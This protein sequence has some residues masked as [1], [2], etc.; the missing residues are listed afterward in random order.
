MK[1]SMVRQVR[2]KIGEIVW[3][4]AEIRAILRRA[5]RMPNR[6]GLIMSIPETMDSGRMLEQDR[7]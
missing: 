5:S 4:V 6:E 1:P 3:R 2:L 7:T